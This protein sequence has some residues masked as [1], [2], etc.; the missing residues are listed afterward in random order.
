[1]IE[2]AT[3]TTAQRRVL[4]A[5]ARDAIGVA[6]VT[7][8]TRVP[9]AERFEPMLRRR[10]ATFVTLE[11]EQRLLGC[12]G[13]L[14]PEHP[15]VTGVAHHALAAAFDDPRLPPVHH[16]DYVAMSVKVSVLSELDPLEVDSLA[17]LRSVVRPGVDGLVVEAAGRRAT[18]LPAVWG[19]LPDVED[20]L[21]ALWRKAGL[22]VGSWD[23]STHAARYTT[24]EFGEAGPRE[25]VERA[26]RQLA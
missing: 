20:F 23:R 1:M 6:L 2:H 3:L 7:G 18:F 15:L 5:V 16:D 4:L 19:H 26:D 10:A 9:D 21:A 14:A 13:T 12:I 22:R 17:E 24:D 8:E 11:R 25:P